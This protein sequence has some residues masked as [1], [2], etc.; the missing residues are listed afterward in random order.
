MGITSTQIGSFL[1]KLIQKGD[2]HAAMAAGKGPVT[3]EWAAEHGYTQ[4]RSPGVPLTKES[5]KLAGETTSLYKTY[6]QDKER[7]KRIKEV[8]KDTKKKKLM[9]EERR[10]KSRLLRRPSK[11]RGIL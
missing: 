7:K 2:P 6:A 4:F 1:T 10:Q 3:A 5:I 9:A 8:K 11:E